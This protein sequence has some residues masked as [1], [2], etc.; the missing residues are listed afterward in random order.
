LISAAIRDVASLD[1]ADLEAEISGRNRIMCSAFLLLAIAS[2]DAD[3]ACAVVDLILEE[4]KPFAG[5]SESSRR[6]ALE[7]VLLRLYLLHANW[8][9]LATAPTRMALLEAAERFPREWVTWRAS[10]DD[11]IENM[12]DSILSGEWRMTRPLAELSRSHPLLILRMIPDMICLLDRDATTGTGKTSGK[13]QGKNVDGA[14]VAAVRGH[15]VRVLIRHWGFTYTEQLWFALLDVVASAP[16]DLLFNSGLK[17]GVLD[18]FTVYLN[19]LSVQLQLFSADRATRL[20]DKLRDCFTLFQRTN[21]SAW[22]RWLDA[23]L[24]ETGREARHV[25]MTCNF[26]TPQEAIDS[27]KVRE[28]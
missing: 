25:L 2:K 17:L 6:L 28:A 10:F 27:L 24:V 12:L 9:N 15:D 3:S 11:Q 5:Q 26:I 18:F 23:T 13:V 20:Q 21:A 22:R 8:V 7:V 4:I 19:L 14:L 1:L 16:G